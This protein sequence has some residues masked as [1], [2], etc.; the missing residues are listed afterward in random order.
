MS[1]GKSLA[2]PR[3][4]LALLVLASLLAA[5]MMAAAPWGP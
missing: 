1:F 5:A 3:V 4:R 2:S